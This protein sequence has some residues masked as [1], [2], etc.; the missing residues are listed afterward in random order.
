MDLLRPID[1]VLVVT[2][3]QAVKAS[4]LRCVR[5]GSHGLDANGD[6]DDAERVA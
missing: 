1:S 5:N 6:G 4:V 2:L 3:E